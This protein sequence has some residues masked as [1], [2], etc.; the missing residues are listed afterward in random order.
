M[1]YTLCIW[2]ISKHT[3][4][5]FRSTPRIQRPSTARCKETRFS[6][7]P[8]QKNNTL[9]RNGSTPSMS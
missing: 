3:G 8:N 9:T 5:R 2:K 7:R 4:R 1:T 6:D